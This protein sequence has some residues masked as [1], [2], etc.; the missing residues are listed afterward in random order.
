MREFKDYIEI[1][2]PE[3]VGTMVHTFIYSNLC[4]HDYGLQ[5]YDNESKTWRL[6]DG[7][8]GF[9]DVTHYIEQSRDEKAVLLNSF[10]KTFGI[11]AGV[12]NLNSYGLDELRKARQT[13]EKLR[14]QIGPVSFAPP[15][16]YMTEAEVETKIA[17]AFEVF[18]KSIINGLA[19]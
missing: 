1:K 11:K 9:Q 14:E 8:K 16:K 18:S 4:W 13:I 2:N 15:E 12:I 5:W 3:G 10:K 6:P 19:K 17:D 7:S